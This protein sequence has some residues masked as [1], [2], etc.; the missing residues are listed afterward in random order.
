MLAPSYLLAPGGQLSTPGGIALAPAAVY[1]AYDGTA[2]L[3][4]RGLQFAA[5][6]Q[7]YAVLPDA[8]SATALSGT[9]WGLKVRDRPDSGA[10]GYV[11]SRNNGTLNEYAIIYGFATNTFEFYSYQQNSTGGT[12]RLPL[13]TATPPGSFYEV[14]FTYD[15]TTLRGYLNGVLSA[16]LTA[17]FTLNSA[18]TAGLLLSA[19][20]GTTAT[21]YHLSHTLDYLRLTR[22][23]A[24]IVAL[25]L[26]EATPPYANTGTA[27]G[28][29]ALYNN[30]TSLL[31]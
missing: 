8:G 27:G 6:S 17:S 30:P 18:G 10:A 25:E 9:S 4:N 21:E 26:N 31:L 23:S 28:A 13:G 2:P 20:M 22:D 19:T 24:A 5:G 1:A 7:Q 14:E 11:L 16:S 3:P 29:L 15:G 12:I